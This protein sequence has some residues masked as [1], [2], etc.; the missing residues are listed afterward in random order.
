MKR[1]IYVILLLV[2]LL[3]SVGCNKE[4]K[5]PDP[6]PAP[7]ATA[8]P[9]PVPQNLAKVTLKKLPE[10]FDN[11]LSYLPQ[12][13]VDYNAGI[14]YDVTMELSVGAQIAELLEL[15]NL[16]SIG[17]KGTLDIKDTMAA[18]LTFCLNDSPVLNSHLLMDSSRLLLNLPDYSAN[19]GEL[20]LEQFLNVP[21]DTAL[22]TNT[23]ELTTIIE[24]HLA[25]FAECFTEVAGVT[26]H[27]S[28]GTGDY[29]LSGDKYTVKANTEE[30]FAILAS[31]ENELSAFLGTTPSVEEYRPEGSTTF[32]LDY[33]QSS[34][35]D[36][37][38]AAY[39]DNEADTPLVFINTKLGFCLYCIH[40]DG[41]TEEIIYSE[42]TT[43]NSGVVTI[44][45]ADE[46]E[47]DTIN[48]EF[49]D[50][51]F[52]MSAMI[53]GLVLS[54]DASKVNETVHYKI[55][56]IMDGM[57][58]VL[59]ETIAPERTD[60][61]C[62]MASY[63]IEYFTLALTAITR[64]YVEIPM[65]QNVVSMDTWKSELNMDDLQSDLAQLRYDYPFLKDLFD[66][67]EEPSETPSSDPS[68]GTTAAKP[69]E[70]K[71]TAPPDFTKLTGYSV[72][73]FGNVDFLPKESEVL[74]QGKP[75]TGF[76]TMKL[77]ETQ[78]Q[79][80]MDYAKK[81]FKNCKESSFTFYWIWGNEE[82]GDVKSYYTKDYN[83]KD[84]ANEEDNSINFEFD[85]VSG[86]FASVHIYHENKETA[87]QMANDLLAL[88]DVNYTITAEAAENYT[89]AR[90]FAFSA[91][92]GFQYGDDYYNISISVSYPEW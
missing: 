36:Y 26:N 14:G 30:V 38:W 18:N 78:N 81:A 9:T 70:S 63:G 91:Y 72:D 53:D 29:L 24:R 75:S 4:K 82:F 10:K 22:P 77:T 23:A 90:N 79:A 71:D 87:L 59:D 74:A 6:T 88:L 12:Q 17:A 85:A 5:N 50:T 76:D 13:S 67:P 52:A 54:L 19:Y 31:L 51:S 58:V 68:E 37:A 32:F 25:D 73:E 66:T 46:E 34:N 84:P 89:F 43:D 7:T 49:S 48:Y 45:A 55:T 16:S 28:I 69:E 65:P 62:S 44:S 92:D 39:P 15:G 61:S 33:Y 21:A 56:I 83:F 3:F 35:G 47:T 41:S 64:D 8:T 11:L 57:S 86:E 20:P 42:K 2:T 40:E 60:V 27:V 1:K 80:I